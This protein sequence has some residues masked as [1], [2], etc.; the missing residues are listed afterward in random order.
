MSEVPL[1]G[2]GSLLGVLAAAALLGVVTRNL[3]G[4]TAVPLFA[5]ILTVA[6]LLVAVLQWRHGLA[7]K[8]FDA[9]YQR[10]ELANRVRLEAFKEIHSNDEEKV[11]AEEKELY[12]F[13]VFTEIDSLEYSMRRYRSGFGLKADIVDRAVRHFRGRCQNSGVFAT[14][15]E[16][17]AREGAYFEETKRA[18]G[19]ILAQAQAE[20]LIERAYEALN[21]GDFD[22]A[23][24]LMHPDVE[25][26]NGVEGGHERGHAALRAHWTRQF[27]AVEPRV[28][29]K[30]Y[31]HK[32][33]G[34]VVVDFEQ[35]V[36]DLRSGDLA[37]EALR[38][39][40][41]LSDRLIARMDLHEN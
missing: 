24:E 37:D 11:A 3:D 40:Y 19:S 23:L 38:H 31:D 10:I 16:A 17:C 39:E 29:P 28:M 27:A 25:W 30:R 5:V 2:L 33:Q 34:R 14:T 26:S 8:G 13:Y 22:A 6:G 20:I 32:G 1:W 18:V 15:A 41:T 4:E 21:A 12:R 9:L 7:E 36:P 35:D